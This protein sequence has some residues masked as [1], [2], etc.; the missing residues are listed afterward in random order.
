MGKVY[1]VVLEYREDLLLVFFVILWR[2][3]IERDEKGD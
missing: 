3:L 1:G 2:L